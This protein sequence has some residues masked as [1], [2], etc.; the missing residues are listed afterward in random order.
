MSKAVIQKKI[1]RIFTTIFSVL[2]VIFVIFLCPFF[3]VT[4]R[5][6]IAPYETLEEEYASAI[7][8]FIE[9]NEVIVPEGAVFTYDNDIVEVKSKNLDGTKVSCHYIL[10][11]TLPVFDITSPTTFS[12]APFFFCCAVLAFL[13]YMI[14]SL[15]A[16]IT[17]RICVKIKNIK[18]KRKRK[19]LEA[20]KSHATYGDRRSSG[21]KSSCITCED[22]DD[23]KCGNCIYVGKCGM[24]PTSDC[25]YAFEELLSDEVERQQ[26]IE[27]ENVFEVEAEKNDDFDSS[28]QFVESEVIEN[29]VTPDVEVVIEDSEQIIDTEENN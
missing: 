7:K 5:E 27:E 22:F 29:E 6:P 3:K 9:E 13:I 16:S 18:D 25:E 14:Y 1:K 2:Y 10:D 20:K 26:D 19:I 23:C 28:E 24:C 15:F 4:V 8:T 12:I 17:Y 11:D 21:Q